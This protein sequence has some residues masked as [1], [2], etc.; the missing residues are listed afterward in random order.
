[1]KCTERSTNNNKGQQPTTTAPQGA[2]QRTKTMNNNIQKIIDQ[3]ETEYEQTIAKYSQTMVIVHNIQKGTAIE[4]ITKNS[5][6]QEMEEHAATQ[7]F[8]KQM[9]IYDQQIDAI[10][11]AKETLQGI[12]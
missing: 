8:V 6:W 9:E 5:T 1:V 10:Q 3:L 7:Y 12:K 4:E 11:K 2:Q